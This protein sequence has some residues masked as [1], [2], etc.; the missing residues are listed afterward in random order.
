MRKIGNKIIQLDR[1]DST[2]NFAA[3][4]LKSGELEHGTVILADEQTAGRGQRG[5]EWQS[6]GGSNLIFSVFVEYDNLTVENQAA[7]NHWVALSVQQLLNELA[8]SSKIKWPND[9]L[10]D[11]YKIA[12]ILIENQLSQSIVKSSIIGIG[13]NVNQIDFGVLKASRIRKVLGEFKPNKEIAFQ[14]IACLN[15]QMNA[16]VNQHFLEL[17]TAYH[18][19]LWKFGETVS[20][21]SK[22]IAKTGKIIGTN[23]SGLLKMEI[24]AKVEVFD[25]KEI[26]FLL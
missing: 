10:V 17:K 26:R 9:L 25:L 12:G 21:E 20:F 22:G 2:N 16:I 1:V 15:Q 8:I 23:E 13:L 11:N 4:L 19:S 5:A 6:E 3:N 18:Q 7:I 14:L 24:D